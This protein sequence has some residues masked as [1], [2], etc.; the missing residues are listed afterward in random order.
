M[1]PL[2][3]MCKLGE[4]LTAINFSFLVYKGERMILVVFPGAIVESGIMHE[5]L[6]YKPK[7]IIYTHQCHFYTFFWVSKHFI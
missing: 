3:L 2:D 4:V 1:Q 6:L 7:R 5:Q